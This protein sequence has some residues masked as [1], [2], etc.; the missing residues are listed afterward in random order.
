M[1]SFEA[2]GLCPELITAVEEKGWL[3]PRDVQDEAIPLILGGADVMIAAETGSGKTGALALPVLQ[4]ITETLRG[5]ATVSAP[6]VMP[7]V[8]ADG[9]PNFQLSPH[10][11]SEPVTIAPFAPSADGGEKPLYGGAGGPGLRAQ[12]RAESGWYGA[13]SLLGVTRGRWYWEVTLTDEGMA[14]IGV[15]T[16]ASPVAGLGLDALSWGYGAAGKTSHA[17]TFG[18]FPAK[19]TAGDTIGVFLDVDAG[20]IGFGK[21]GAFVAQAFA[22][23]PKGGAAPL[24]P[25]VLISNADVVVNFAGP[26]VATDLMGYKPLGS[27][28]VADT[29]AAAAGTN[30]KGTANKS[31]GTN[32]K[33]GAKAGD[34]TAKSDSASASHVVC[35]ILEPTRE[36]A[37]QVYEELQSFTAHLT[38]PSVTMG[39]LTPNG[40]VASR[41]GGAAKSNN[42]NGKKG[43]DNSDA[44]AA[45][46]FAVKLP[47]S[48]AYTAHLLVGTVACVRSAV[49]SGEVSLSKARFFVLDEADELFSGSSRALVMELAAAL[50]LAPA[51]RAQRIIC[52]ATLH[53]LDARA[54][55]G[56]L[57]RTPQLVDLKGETTVPVNVDHVALTIDALRDRS[58]VPADWNTAAAGAAGAGAGDNS[59]MPAGW[60]KT[61][62]ALF[63]G[64]YSGLDPE[65]LLPR[66]SGLTF[67]DMPALDGKGAEGSVSLAGL[68]DFT[69]GIHTL[70]NTTAGSDAAEV[71]S[72]GVKS[73]KLAALARI[74][75]TLAPSSAIVFCRTRVDCD[76][77]A[78]FL[79]HCG[80]SALALHAGQVCQFT[81]ILHDIDHIPRFSTTSHF[82]QGFSC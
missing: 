38:A 18:D 51:P 69:D 8:L 24:F 1:S 36:L 67:R 2:L 71:L 66:E 40:A 57:C 55:A 26:F 49:A 30:N 3:L 10:D 73:L 27:A 79:V 46:S 61:E 53:S 60:P 64:T 16:A 7:V 74:I 22:N 35:V 48:A 28:Q 75:A 43:D 23:L 21:N 58:W 19:Y 33:G 76:L 25:A 29:T 32:A 65:E 9:R 31:G 70:L 12:C 82:K 68:R 41:S 13:R 72:F 4:L 6:D 45:S 34:K 77:V 59:N 62:P 37:Q 11:R 20:T 54:M 17:G 56:A 42:N 47:N 15:S 81:L 78:R 63:K 14:R 44:A 50:P 80:H 5:V 39:L 52:S